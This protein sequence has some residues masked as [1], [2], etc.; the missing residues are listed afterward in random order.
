MHYAHK[1]K[2]DYL[3]FSLKNYQM[4]FL[5]V[6][7]MRGEAQKEF[8]TEI[9]EVW[10]RFKAIFI[11]YFR[12]TVVCIKQLVQNTFLTSRL[13]PF[14]YR[15]VE[16]IIEDTPQGTDSIAAKLGKFFP[17]FFTFL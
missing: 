11:A 1:E 9:G 6:L 8:L 5:F 4:V 15:F 12:D 16:Y 14:V 2:K 10:Q 3:T 7:S 17:L 13:H